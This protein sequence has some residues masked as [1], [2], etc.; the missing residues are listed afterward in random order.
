[1]LADLAF[2]RLLNKYSFETVLDIG[3]GD[4]EHAKLLK[5]HGKAVTAISLQQ[6]ADIIGDFMTTELDQYQCIWASHVLEHQ[7]NVGAFLERCFDLLTDDG[8]LAVTVPPLKHQ[9]VGGHVTLWNAGLLLY[10]LV[11]AGFD[12]S[13]AE[14]KSYGYNISVIVKK[15]QA[16]LPKLIM[17]SGDIDAISKFLPN[18]G[19]EQFDGQIESIN[20]S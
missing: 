7:R 10:N 11:L 3:C 17:D 20:W 4:C 8:I 6:P 12:C 19:R 5:Q 15:K 16:F 18:K 1:M 9:I 14:V 13:D 2:Y